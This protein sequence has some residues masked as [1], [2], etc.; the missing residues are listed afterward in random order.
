M[1]SIHTN[2]ILPSSTF[3]IW[4]L[5][6]QLHYTFYCKVCDI[7]IFICD[8]AVYIQQAWMNKNVYTFD[9]CIRGIKV[10]KLCQIFGTVLTIVNMSDKENSFRKELRFI[11]ITYSYKHWILV[12]RTLQPLQRITFSFKARSS[13]FSSCR[14]WPNPSSFLYSLYVLLSSLKQLRYCSLGVKQ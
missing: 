9:G 7:D 11:N 6:Q 13:Y 14:G 2:A 12:M 8:H 4:F 10:T 3:S 1:T 5:S